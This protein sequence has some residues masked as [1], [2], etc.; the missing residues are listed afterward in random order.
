[1]K[2]AVAFK[3]H[4]E[5]LRQFLVQLILYRIVARQPSLLKS[6]LL[7]ATINETNVPYSDPT[8]HQLNFI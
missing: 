4:W 5:N 6:T 2:P 7:C 1:M 3:L 8:T